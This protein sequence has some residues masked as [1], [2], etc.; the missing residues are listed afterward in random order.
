MQCGRPVASPA[1]GGTMQRRH[2]ESD[3]T[4]FPHDA[5]SVYGYDGIAWHVYGWEIE[6]ESDVESAWADLEMAR[7][8]KVVCVMVGDD[9]HF[10]F[11]TD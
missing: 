6:P 3:D 4:A 9:R 2:F 11:G 8:G 7:T 5:Y 10:A 1:T